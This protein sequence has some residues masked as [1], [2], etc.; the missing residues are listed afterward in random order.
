[1]GRLPPFGLLK[2]EPVT[3]ERVDGT[4][5]DGIEAL[6]RQS[7]LSDQTVLDVQTKFINQARYKGDAETLTCI[8]P[9]SNTEDLRD[10][11]VWVRGNR[12]R[13]YGGPFA[14]TEGTLPTQYNRRVTLNRALYLYDAYLLEPH[15]TFDAWKVQH[16]E[17]RHTTD[18]PIK[19]NLLRLATESLATDYGQT[20]ADYGI[21]LL[22]MTPDL[23]H[24]EPAFE[25]GGTHYTVT[26]DAT[27]HD[28]VIVTGRGDEAHG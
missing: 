5:V 3:L 18:E 11:H 2:G 12:Y 10:C 28:T 13:V 26:A 15:E 23:Y 6:V 1:M 9:K 24:G 8:W 7:D 20:R 17:W 4:M 22:E 19:V 27:A 21:V 25:F 14:P 16:I